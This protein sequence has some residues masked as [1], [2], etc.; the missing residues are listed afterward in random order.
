MITKFFDSPFGYVFTYGGTD[1]YG[2]NHVT[3][4]TLAKTPQ[5]LYD[6][7]KSWHTYG[8]KNNEI[9]SANEHFT[10]TVNAIFSIDDGSW[11][12][13]VRHNAEVRVGN[14]GREVATTGIKTKGCG[15]WEINCY[16]ALADTLEGHEEAY[17]IQCEQAKQERIRKAHEDAEIRY[18]EYCQYKPA[19]WALYITSPY[20]VCSQLCFWTIADSQKDAYEKLHDEIAYAFSRTI[21]GVPG[22][23][24]FTFE[25]YDI[26]T[27]DDI[28]KDEANER[29]AYNENSVKEVIDD[30]RKFIAWC[31]PIDANDADGR[32]WLK[33][34]HGAGPYR[35]IV[36]TGKIVGAIEGGFHGSNNGKVSVSSW[37]EAL[38]R[39]AR[40]KY[41][42][43]R[44]VKANGSGTYFYLCYDEHKELFANVK[45]YYVP[46][47]GTHM[48]TKNM[49]VH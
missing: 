21:K 18:N 19:N 8:N 46:T 14:T 6:T 22:W 29:G 49:E 3:Y 39:A 5:E 48:L 38:I 32:Y 42:D 20:D 15:A 12:D 30:A 41:A 11:T 34:Y 44:L 26:Q 1:R 10:H 23:Q 47:Y 17:R 31:N 25:K 43:C 36:S 37:A 9:I 28:E 40:E 16:I 33:T 45:E 4:R 35:L 24:S 7:M 27:I 2:R 13:V